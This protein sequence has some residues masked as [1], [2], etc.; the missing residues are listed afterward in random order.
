MGWCCDCGIGEVAIGR[1]EGGKS[2]IF[3]LVDEKSPLCLSLLDL[4]PRL[5]VAAE[6]IMC[7]VST[8]RRPRLAKRLK[9]IIVC[10]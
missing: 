3:L 6:K 9:I 10:D 7:L 4:W 5:E 8:K 2:G 1:R